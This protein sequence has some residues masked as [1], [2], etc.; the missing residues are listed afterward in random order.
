[1]IG[2]DDHTT[3]PRHYKYIHINSFDRVRGDATEFRCNLN[4]GQ[5]ANDQIVDVT[6]KSIACPNLFD[7]VYDGVNRLVV[8]ESG[9][10]YTITLSNGRYNQATMIDS[11]ETAIES[12]VPGV[13]SAVI[14]VDSLT[15]RWTIVTNIPIKLYT[16]DNVAA[17]SS[18]TTISN[19]LANIIGLLADTN[20][21][22]SHTFTGVPTLDQPNEAYFHIDMVGYN[23]TSSSGDSSQL[24][25]VLPLA[26]SEYGSMAVMRQ[27]TGNLNRFVFKERIANRVL[28]KIS[29]HTGLKLSLPENVYCQIILRIGIL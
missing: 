20:I 27:E 6:V 23:T 26:N 4:N 1:M 21:A 3:L 8:E 13:T 24:A 2:S 15:G 22:T 29:D 12:V 28:V 19:H 17:L 9:T 25:E 5:F 16:S 14:S 11:I 18:D 7:N 10:K